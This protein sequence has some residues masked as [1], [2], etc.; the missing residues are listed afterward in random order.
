MHVSSAETTGNINRNNARINA[1]MENFFNISPYETVFSSVF[2][3]FDLRF[4]KI[5]IVHIRKCGHMAKKSKEKAKDIHSIK[6]CP[7][8]ASQNL[9]YNEER[10]QVICRDCGLIYE[11]LAPEM[12]KQFA[13]SHG[14]IPVRTEMPEKLMMKITEEAA[15]KKA[16][17]PKKKAAKKKPAKKKKPVKKKAKPKKAVKKKPAKKKAVKKKAKKAKK[18]SIFGRLKARLKKK[19]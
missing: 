18:K 7:D 14:P 8:C 10:Q 13:V 9:V 11:P 2:K 16:K 3:L 6:E 12:E 1:A 19:R 5:Y 4:R 15:P 17:K